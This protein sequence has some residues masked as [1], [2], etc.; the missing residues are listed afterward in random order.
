MTDLDTAGRLRGRT[1]VVTGGNRG[2]GLGIA[3]G[4]G[5]AGAAVAIWGRD[6]ARNTDAVAELVA[7]GIRAVAVR[8]DVSQEPSVTDAFAAT[9]AS[10][11][12]VD[13]LFA[14]AGITG[15]TPFIDMSLDEWHRV[16]S[17]NLDGVF[18]CFRAAARHMVE[19]GEGGAL[20]AI[21][22][23]SAYHGAPRQEHYAASKAAVLAMVRG[24]AV[25][26]A[27]HR[28]R[29]NSLVPGWTDTEMLA[30][31]RQNTRFETNTV[32]RTPVRRWAA[33]DDFAA[34]AVFLAD[35]T[36]TFHTGTELVLDGGYTIF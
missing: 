19:R 34:P 36:Q 16:L 18:L 4:V 15:V 6:E 29:C 2:I 8:C 1:V 10:F 32:A 9:L 35:P 11:G 24:L 14:N 3:R 17:V 26:L 25:E 5:R 31:A 13:C 12:A 23:T 27:R 7:E 33:L 30:G 22:S 20:V 28:V 21:S